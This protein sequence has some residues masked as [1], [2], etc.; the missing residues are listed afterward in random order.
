M[1]KLKPI[2]KPQ[3][4]RYICYS[5]M[6]LIMAFAR[7]REGLSPFNLG[8]LTA[9]FYSGQNML[10]LAPVYFAVSVLA[11]PTIRG[12][13]VSVAPPL[14]F[15]AVW[16]LHKVTNRQIKLVS[17]MV[18]SALSLIPQ[19]VYGVNGLSDLVTALGTVL[20]AALV[21]CFSPGSII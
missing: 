12:L 17:A 21:I 7:T 15:A 1:I 16:F 5:L 18:Y 10:I 19:L 6:L 13:I 20:L 14:I 8:M 2:N 3:T 4:I 9:L 11:E